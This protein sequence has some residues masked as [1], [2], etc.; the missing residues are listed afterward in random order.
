MMTFTNK[1]LLAAAYASVVL[2]QMMVVEDIGTA[3]NE[4]A[5]STICIPSCRVSLYGAGDACPDGSS[6]TFGG[7][8]YFL[9]DG[10]VSGTLDV[11]PYGEKGCDD[12][13]IT[14][15]NHQFIATGNN[16]QFNL[17]VSVLKCYLSVESGQCAPN[18]PPDGGCDVQ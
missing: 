12:F 9:N 8:C 2:G 5:G 14:F 15:D 17:D 13:K 4:G 11:E 10:N 16:G 7:A 1:L 6:V 3:T 18:S